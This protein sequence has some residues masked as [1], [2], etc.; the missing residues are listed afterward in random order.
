MA[1]GVP[2]AIAVSIPIAV[3]IP[4]AVS[5]LGFPAVES[6]PTPRG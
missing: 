1:I 3:P 6:D 2:I 4:I 5:D